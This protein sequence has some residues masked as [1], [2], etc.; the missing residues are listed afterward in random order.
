MPVFHIEISYENSCKVHVFQCWV[1]LR[2]SR[3]F[4][5]LLE[6][7]ALTAAEIHLSGDHSLNSGR[8]I[9]G[10]RKMFILSLNASLLHVK[11]KGE[12][13]KINLSNKKYIANKIV[14]CSLYANEPAFSDRVKG[15]PE[16]RK[17]F[18]NSGIFF[19]ILENIF[20]NETISLTSR[21][22]F[23]QIEFITNWLKQKLAIL[24][25]ISKFSP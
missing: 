10:F 23:A 13:F 7:I 20:T 11:Y 2:T 22:I 25:K 16:F 21:V 9:V 3:V 4:I 18:S 14:S 17:I 6:E 12:N 8:K 19:R 1:L 5:R 15:F 24:I